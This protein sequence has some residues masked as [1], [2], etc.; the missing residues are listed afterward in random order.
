MGTTAPAHKGVCS[1]VLHSGVQVEPAGNSENAKVLLL[2]KII[3]VK[4]Q[5]GLIRAN[6]SQQGFLP[7]INLNN[8]SNVKRDLTVY[9]S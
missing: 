8:S 5:E 2:G 1:T 4:S 7:S 6:A 9:T 3:E